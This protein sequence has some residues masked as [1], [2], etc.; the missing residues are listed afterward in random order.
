MNAF[1]VFMGMTVL[2]LIDTMHVEAVF[3]FA[4]Y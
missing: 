2:L 1:L 4:N 3:S